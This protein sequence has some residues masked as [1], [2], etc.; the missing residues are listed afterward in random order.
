MKENLPSVSLRIQAAF[1]SYK[2]LRFIVLR[3]FSFFY[4][5]TMMLLGS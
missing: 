2:N 5:Y 4:V 1:S 3:E